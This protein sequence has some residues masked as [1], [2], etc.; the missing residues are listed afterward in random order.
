MAAIS[1]SGL[2]VRPNETPP[3]LFGSY[4]VSG[5]EE[6]GL[7][8]FVVSPSISPDHHPRTL[9]TATNTSSGVWST[10]KVTVKFELPMDRSPISVCS[11][12][13]PPL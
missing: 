13:R 7:A 11:F 8:E 9:L 3:E 2:T 6:R 12:T 4:L 10:E 5:T 1:V